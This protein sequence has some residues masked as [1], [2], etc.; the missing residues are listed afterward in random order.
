MM[1]HNIKAVVRVARQEC[2]VHRKS[3]YGKLYSQAY[4]QLSKAFDTL[5]EIELNEQLDVLDSE[6]KNESIEAAIKR[7]H[8]KV[9]Q[10]RREGRI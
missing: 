4:K 9:E 5:E 7:E 8:E 6:K 10:L 2:R 3:K 1:I